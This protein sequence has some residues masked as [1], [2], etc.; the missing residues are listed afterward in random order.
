M[1]RLP[2]IAALVA[3]VN[4]L[5]IHLPTPQ[6]GWNSYNHYGC[7]PTEEIMKSNA[8]GLVDH[9][10]AA[11][12]YV[13]VTPDCGWMTGER[14]PSTGELVWNATLFPSGG[15]ALGDY[16]HGLG[17]KFGVYSGGG[18]YQCDSVLRPASLGHESLDAQTFASWGADSLKYD[19]C[20]S[21][22]P[23]DFVDY[24]SPE[25]QSPD[26]YYTMAEALNAT[27]RDILFQVCQWGV[28]YDIGTW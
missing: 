22:S 9:G 15:L 20:Y 3:M 27:S 7:V 18:Y 6:L 4:A 10:L 13:Y 11:L 2:L 17:L 28:G 26:R 14:D 21:T 8:Q 24:S 23:T 5:D 12:G 25:S 16:I 1:A 19:N